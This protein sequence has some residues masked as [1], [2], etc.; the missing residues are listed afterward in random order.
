L[1]VASTVKIPVRDGEMDAYL[2]AP[3]RRAPGPA[4]VLMYHRTGIDD[5]T[6]GVADRLAGAGYVVAVPDV[7]HRCP[8]TMP[9]PERKALLNDTEII[10]D[11]GSMIDALRKR[12]DVDAG[13]IVVM[14]HC[15][16]GRMALLL[17]GSSASFCAAV[18]YYGGGVMRS[19]GEG[20]T[21]FE[22]LRNIRCPVIGFFGNEDKNPSPEEVDQIDAELKRH[23]I[24]HHFHRYPCV[25]HGF[26]NPNRV[27]ASERAAAEDAWTK[28]LAFLHRVA[29]V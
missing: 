2:G 6:K 12:A 5:F 20:P 24:E 1:S 15:M 19:W 27:T 14:G 8:N 21:V 3:A 9:I 10:D 23:D 7:Y 11:V 4:I 26:Q 13:R 17:A 22:R 16:G 28:T 18:V 25:G 29:P